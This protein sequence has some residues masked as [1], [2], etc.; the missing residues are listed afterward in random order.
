MFFRVNG[1]FFDYVM[2]IRLNGNLICCD[3]EIE[4]I[5]NSMKVRKLFVYEILI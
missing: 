2:G 1:D 3:I 5:V 4:F